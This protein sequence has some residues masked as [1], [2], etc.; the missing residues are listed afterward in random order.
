MTTEVF[1]NLVV[2][3][4]LGIRANCDI[5]YCINTE[6]DVDFM[7]SDG[8]R[9]FEFAIATEA[10]RQLVKVCNCALSELDTRRVLGTTENQP[11]TRHEH[12]ETTA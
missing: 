6:D 4:W 1:E 12:A 10:L 7:L 8:A 5:T 9:R 3:A 2:S 11:A